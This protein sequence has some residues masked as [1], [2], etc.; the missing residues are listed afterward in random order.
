MDGRKKSKGTPI[1]NSYTYAFKWKVIR[2][3]DR[4]K[5]LKRDLGAR[6]GDV[7]PN[8]D[9]AYN[10][11]ISH[12][13][14]TAWLRQ[15]ATI[16]TK[17]KSNRKSRLTRV[18]TT[19]Y[20]YGAVDAALIERVK[21]I[22]GRKRRVGPRKIK[23]WYTQM[24]REKFPDAAVRFRGS[25]GFLTALVKRC[26]FSLRRKTNNHK[27]GWYGNRVVIL[28]AFFPPPLVADPPSLPPSLVSPVSRRCVGPSS[29]P[30]PSGWSASQGSIGS[31]AA[32]S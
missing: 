17:A 19:R 22:R 2:D 12:S 10:N 32:F 30:T 13:L 28:G 1:R 5:K 18:G 31:L 4:L 14:V 24:L 8:V 7:C 26:R 25:R 29:F 9:A 16:T 11:N 21:E 15:R 20:R 3:Y 6:A 27:L 23:V